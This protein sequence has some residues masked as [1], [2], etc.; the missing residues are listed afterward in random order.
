MLAAT[1]TSNRSIEANR[2][3]RADPD[4]RCHRTGFRLPLRAVPAPVPELHGYRLSASAVARRILSA[5]RAQPRRPGRS[6]S[7]HATPRPALLRLVIPFVRR[8]TNGMTVIETADLGRQRPCRADRRRGLDR[9][10]RDS[11]RDR[12]DPARPRPA[13]HPSGF[14]R[15]D[16]P[17]GRTFR[18]RHPFDGFL[19][20]GDRTVGPVSGMALGR[21]RPGLSQ[22][23]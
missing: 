6:S 19:R 20:L 14:G 12:R 17:V 21:V 8:E 2:G 5:D 4:G 3:R 13:A 22:A 9:T 23:P 7:P 16:R 1:S 11:R 18:R 15:H 10:G